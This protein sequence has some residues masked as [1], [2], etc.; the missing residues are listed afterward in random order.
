MITDQDDLR[1]MVEDLLL[2]DSLKL[3]D[4]EINFLDDIYDQNGP[5]GDGQTAKINE[6]Y[7]KRTRETL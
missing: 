3:T 6:I 1:N 4:W 2:G 7:D 5:F